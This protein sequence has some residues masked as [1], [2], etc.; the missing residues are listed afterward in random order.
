MAPEIIEGVTLKQ[1]FTGG[2]AILNKEKNIINALN[3]FPVP[4]GDTGT[5]MFLTLNFAVEQ[6]RKE[7][8]ETVGEV[9]QSIADSSLMGARGNSGVILS[10]LFRGLSKG[11]S[12]REKINVKEFVEALQEGVNT[13]YKAVMKPVE[14]TMLTVAK[15]AANSA[16]READ[17]G[18]DF[19]VLL[20]A[21]LKQAEDTLKKTPDML[22]VLK[23][24][25]VVDAG[26]KGLCA[27]YEGFLKALQGYDF[28]LEKEEEKEEKSV[29][30]F[31]EEDLA[32]QY[33][34]EYILKGEN[35]KVESLKNELS[36]MGDSLLI[37]G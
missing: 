12:G 9:A 18:A 23:E 33:C 30:I 11:L 22:P 13:A 5:N 24:A 20:E 4:D 3:V 34:T 19:M 25:G 28:D 7:E 21:L 27:I 37:V 31:L 1:M 36:S 6:L 29:K 17:K 10:Q 26:G 15:E 16:V 14:G 35:M 8:K 32:Y 2:L